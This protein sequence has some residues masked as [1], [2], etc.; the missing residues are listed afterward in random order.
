MRDGNTRAA[1]LPRPRDT[2]HRRFAVARSRSWL[3]LELLL[4]RDIAQDT[5][6][7]IDVL[8]LDME[9]AKLRGERYEKESKVNWTQ[10][11]KI[12]YLTVLLLGAS[13]RSSILQLVGVASGL[14]LIIFS[15]AYIFRVAWRS[16]S[17]CFFLVRGRVGLLANGRFGR[18]L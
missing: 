14:G 11:E 13:G 9:L 16:L 1:A 10:N 17:F 15:V 7:A 2:L 12:D 18:P 6:H 3:D 4:V 8:R 5:K